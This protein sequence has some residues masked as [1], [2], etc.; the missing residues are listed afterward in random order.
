MRSPP[1][2]FLLSFFIK[3]VFHAA[4]D[5]GTSGEFID[6]AGM[7]VTR[8]CDTSPSIIGQSTPVIRSPKSSDE[9]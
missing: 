1:G 4:P 6:I 5:P 8:R 9:M 2:R 3:T 7:I